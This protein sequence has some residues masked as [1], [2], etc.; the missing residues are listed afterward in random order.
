MAQGFAGTEPPATWPRLTGTPRPQ[1]AG[2]PVSSLAGVGPALEKKLAKLGLRSVRD[3][4]EHRPHRY[5]A[6]VPERRIAG[7]ERLWP[8]GARLPRPGSSVTLRFGPLLR[9]ED[10]GLG[11]DLVDVALVPDD[12]PR[13]VLLEHPHHQPPQ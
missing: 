11:A 4:L 2:A 5:E 10:L 8:V 13:T 6:A 1:A 9:P 7:S 3:L 12:R